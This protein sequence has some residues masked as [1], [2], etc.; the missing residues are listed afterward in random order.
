MFVKRDSLVALLTVCVALGALTFAQTEKQLMGSS[1]FDWTAISVTPTKVGARRAFFQTPTAT[2]PELECHV[3]TINPGEAP[4]APH[5]HAHEELIIVKEGTVEVTT[6][7]QTKM[8]GPGSVAFQASNQM[9]GLKNVGKEPATYFVMTWKSP[10]TPRSG[11][12]L[13]GSSIFEW[14]TIPVKPTEVGERRS[15]FQQPTA[16]LDELEFHVS[17]L[18]P[19]V[20]S[21]PPH[22][23]PNEELIII[24]EGSIESI[25]GDQKKI[26]GPGSVI[27]AATNQF[28]SVRNAGT[29]PGTYFVVN[30]KS[31]ATPKPEPK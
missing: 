15:F 28:H 22:Q 3:T 25:L 8:I 14:S 29:V 26:V 10:G 21:H 23:H 20:A 30:W 11:P 27:F 7:G 5:Q 6:S 31:S 2:L 24:K 13:M 4:H 1:V 12:N 18:N 19:G 17:T 16:T 9:H